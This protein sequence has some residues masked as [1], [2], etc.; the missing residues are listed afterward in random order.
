MIAIIWAKSALSRLLG[1][2]KANPLLVCCIALACLSAWLWHGKAEYREQ[3]ASEI[4]SHKA[5]IAQWQATSKAAQAVADKARADAKDASND[6]QNL[7]DKLADATDGLERYIADHRVQPRQ[8]PAVA[9]KAGPG[10]AASV[11]AIPATSPGVEV[12]AA[13][14]RA[15]DSAWVYAQSAFQWA[16]DLKAKG[17]AE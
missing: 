15:C 14:V 1:A 10:E 17:L 6:A 4:K 5:D 12:S 9:A 3:L 11:P 8:C 2:F 16:Q 7:H 13:T